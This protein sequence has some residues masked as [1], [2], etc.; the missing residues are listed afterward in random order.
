[1]S[2]EEL[3]MCFYVYMDCIDV[4]YLQF[5]HSNQIIHIIQLH[6]NA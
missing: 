4:K 3:A 5:L 2:T 1:M 6:Q